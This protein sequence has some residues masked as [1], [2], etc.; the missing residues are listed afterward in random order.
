MA[1]N[2]WIGVKKS[3]KNFLVMFG[4]GILAFLAKVP[5]EYAAAAGFLAYLLKNYL[6]NK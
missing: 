3:F 6:E 1:Y 5:L 4:P 2:F